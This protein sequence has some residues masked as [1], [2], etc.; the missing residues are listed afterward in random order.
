[1]TE[2]P[3][4]ASNRRADAFCRSCGAKLPEGASFCPGC[5]AS[6]VTRSRD[7]VPVARRAPSEV[8][9]SDYLAPNLIMM[10]PCCCAQPGAIVALGFSLAARSAQRNGRRRVAIARAAVAQT[11]FWFN[12]IFAICAFVCAVLYACA[13]AAN[14]FFDRV[15]CGTELRDEIEMLNWGLENVEN[16]LVDLNDDLIEGL[17]YRFKQL[18]RKLSDKIEKKLH[19]KAALPETQEEV[20]EAID[21]PE[22]D[23]IEEDAARDASSESNGD[24]DAPDGAEEESRESDETAVG[25]AFRAFPTV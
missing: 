4:N 10:V 13:P 20:E 22:E 16:D 19:R 14:K 6:R 7:D 1:M 17:D 3:S 2:I 21:Q 25:V 11:L 18:E 12:L 9:V 8:F 24:A 23:E 15:L 5:G